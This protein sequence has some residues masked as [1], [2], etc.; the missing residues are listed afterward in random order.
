MRLTFD[1]NDD[2]R[3]KQM[4]RDTSRLEALRV[5]G[6]YGLDKIPGDNDIN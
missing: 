4:D 2:R 6:F 3:F 1:G 5:F